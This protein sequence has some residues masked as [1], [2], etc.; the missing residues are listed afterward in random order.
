[1]PPREPEED[2]DEGVDE[3]ENE[4]QEGGDEDESEGEGP[5]EG[6]VS[7]S[8][9]GSEEGLDEEP[10]EQSRAAKRFQKIRDEAR[11]ARAEAAQA[12]K[13]IDEL[14]A[15]RQQPVGKSAEMIAAEEALMTP[16]ERSESRLTRLIDE[17]RRQN[18]VM[19]FQMQDQ[20]DR[21][22]YQAK[23]VNNPRYAKYADKVEAKLAE[24]RKGGGNTD[25][26]TV[27]KYLIGEAV[28]A[29]NGKSPQAKKG[30]DAV[31]RQQ[32]RPTN[33]RG[34]QPADR[35][36]SSSLAKRLEDLPL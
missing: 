13:E 27:L 29:N 8:G 32:A 33:G 12:R 14:K 31:R 18:S 20:S 24:V 6:G 5:G 2:L 17:Q 25:R 10:R 3:V 26:E 21:N 7:A 30:A 22:A 1:M 28:M 19:Q 34:D 4:G 15:Q 11:A 35:R 16:E 23:A 36:A 9:E